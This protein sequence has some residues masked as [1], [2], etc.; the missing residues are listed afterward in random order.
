MNMELKNTYQNFKSEAKGW[1][2]VYSLQYFTNL[3]LD[4]QLNIIKL[5]I[6]YVWWIPQ[7]K[8]SM[9]VPEYASCGILLYEQNL[10]MEL[11]T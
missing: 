2:H 4:W 9:I 6:N 8:Q 10:A 3:K 11:H 5:K 1:T 7:T